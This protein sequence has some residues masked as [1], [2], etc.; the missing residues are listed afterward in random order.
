[1]AE[2][3]VDR[4]LH[5][6]FVG[7]T[8]SRR[9]QMAEGLLRELA[10]DRTLAASAGLTAGSLDPGA[11]SAMRDRGIDISQQR[12]KVL[13]EA[14]DVIYDLVVT[15]DARAHE[16]GR[17]HHDPQDQGQD[18]ARALRAG[19]P[20]L[21]HWPIPDAG[22]A[23][24]GDAAALDACRAAR[25]AIQARIQALVD[26]GFLDT[27]HDRV[28]QSEAV[29]DALH[30][31]LV[32]HDDGQRIQGFN[33][34][35]ERMTGFRRETV[36]GRHCHEVFGPG[37]ICGGQCDFLNGAPEEFQRREREVPFV[38]RQGE[39]R[40]LKMVVS[41]ELR[42]EGAGGRVVAAIRNVTELAK[43][44]SQNRRVHSLH[45]M[46]AISAP[47]QEV[48]ESIRLVS[49]SDYPTL[50]LGESGT[51]K[52]LTANAIHNESRRRGGPFVPINCGALPEN[53]LESELFGHVRGAFTGAIREK[54]GR[55]EL[56]DRGTLFLD[57]VGELSPAFQ[58]RLLRVLQEK[59][60]EKVGG[61]RSISVDVRIV[62]ATNR[63]LKKMVAD[64]EFREDL[65]YRLCVVPITPPPSGT[66]ART[67][68]SSSS[69]CSS[70]SAVNRA[71][72]SRPC[73]TTRCAC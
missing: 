56:A 35:A 40:L 17:A 5:V 10:G 8:N 33:R 43:L 31:G 39:N 67:S 69:R 71:R 72:T 41:R 28:R 61:E 36:I 11:V 15:F 54:K 63:D 60:F 68:R 46:A 1:M 70:R 19:V 21:L 66:A 64:G 3:Q 59:R 58:V 53:I 7:G 51:G 38:T 30:D 44:R 12:A 42:G 22:T 34:A 55:F 18:P 47:M 27:L 52:E 20:A 73:P 32:I 9:S 13:E 45:G 23:G 62:S 25:D 6:L 16:L 26:Q 14:G 4:K 2:A 37:G 65:F 24:D 49:A 29:L 48:F 50:I 57:E